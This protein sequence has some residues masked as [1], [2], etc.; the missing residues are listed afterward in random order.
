MNSWSEG[1]SVIGR[2]RQGLFSNAVILRP[3]TKGRIPRT[4]VST[5]GSSGM[6]Q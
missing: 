3:S 4:M 1:D 2:Q 6:W 5:S